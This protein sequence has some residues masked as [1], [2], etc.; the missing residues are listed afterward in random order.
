MSEV[1]TSINRLLSLYLTKGVQPS[2]L[3][4]NLYDSEY[5]DFSIN[6]KNKSLLL[7]LAYIE[8]TEEGSQKITMK[9][10]YDSE[11]YLL[12]I[13]QKINS[14]RFSTQWCRSRALKMAISDFRTAVTRVGLSTKEAE[15]I[16]L[17]L[18]S[19]L[20]SQVKAEL[21]LVA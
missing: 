9:Y 15:K 14:Q 2:D 20:M 10:E 4:E 21:K 12:V 19:Q 7:E 8:S 16:L 18:P 6:K 1:N 5:T 13:K 11:R 3:V 17:T